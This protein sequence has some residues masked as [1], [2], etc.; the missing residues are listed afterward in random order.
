MSYQLSNRDTSGYVHFVVT[1]A[2][3]PD[4]VRGYLREALEIC[5]QRRSR[6][7]LIEENLTGPEL[8]LVDIYSIV[9][10]SSE[11]P[12]AH[13]LKVAFVNVNP[14]HER[15]STAFAETVARNRG[16]NVRAFA[17]LAEAQQWLRGE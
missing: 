7:V 2:N 1:G 13:L 14:E 9:T 17:T 11:A 8:R 12:L 5:A 6:A 15:S 16:V 4:A 10:E 3:T